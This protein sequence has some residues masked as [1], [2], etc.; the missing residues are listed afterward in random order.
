MKQRLKFLLLLLLLMPLSGVAQTE[1][2]EQQDSVQLVMDSLRRE[3][4]ELKLKEMMMQHVLDSTGR[5]ARED[6]MRQALRQQQIDSLR[7]ITPGVPVIVEGDTLFNIYAS[8]GGEGPIHRAE[9]IAYKVKQ[10]GKSL[11]TTTDSVFVF[12]SELTS[13]I[14]CGEVVVMRVSELD[15]LWAGKSRQEL[16]R[17]RMATIDTTIAQLQKEY[18][19][20]AKLYGLCWAV[21]LIVLQILFFILTSRFIAWLRREIA[22]GLR[23]RLRSLVVKGYELLNLQQVKRILF[24]L[25]RIL[26]AVLVVLQLFI[27]LPTL[28]IIFPETEKFTWNMIYYVWEPLRDIVVTTVH[29]FPNLVK[30]AVIIYVV[31]WLLKGIRHLSNEVEAG[32]LKLDSFYQDWAQPTYHIIRIFVIA[33]TL[34]IVWPLLPGSDS[35]VFKGVSIFVA[36]LFSLGSSVSI[37]NLVSGIII[38]YMRPFLVGDFVQIGE[39]EGTVIEK[40]SFTTR[41]RD[42]KENIITVPNNSIL[43]Q[44]TV[45]YTAAVRQA[46]G[47][48]VHSDFT[49]TYKVFREQIEPLLLQAAGRCELL[50]KTP[51]PFVLVTQLEDFYTRY[52]IN[53]YTVE[54][55]RLFEVY[56]ELHK[57]ILDVFRENNLE[58]TSSHFIRMS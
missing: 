5:S 35:G 11:R 28:F 38:T 49:F 18:G 43:S 14:M 3:V 10:L 17:D 27:S 6:S 55:Q 21:V 54:S 1:P 24:I 8:L 37:G 4:Q 26:Q 36:A 32:R 48:I 57:N 46:G 58:P 29:Y 25:A 42:I 2:T 53:A 13:D 45:N 34:I 16:A 9:N 40:N 33:F 39:H 50:L 12:N 44:T 15:G 19:L 7:K 52:Q 56:S 22:G 23:G 30:I 41:L 20:K 31:R 47:T 51:P